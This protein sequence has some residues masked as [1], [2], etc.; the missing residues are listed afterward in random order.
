M[1]SPETSE[2]ELENNDSFLHEEAEQSRGPVPVWVSLF[3]DSLVMFSETP[4]GSRREFA[5]SI[6]E[7]IS[8]GTEG[9]DEDSGE[10]RKLTIS[11]RNAAGAEH[12]WTLTSQH[13]G[14]LAA[15]ERKLQSAIE[16]RNFLLEQSAHAK[17]AAIEHEIQAALGG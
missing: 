2:E 10:Q 17:K 4:L 7:D 16:K 13:I 12:R 5:C 6:F 8:I 1:L 3:P 11:L 14:N 15:C 9:G